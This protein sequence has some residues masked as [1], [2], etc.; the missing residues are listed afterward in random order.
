[1]PGKAIII[2]L[3]G[4]IVIMGMVL[5]GI[6]NT[7]NNISKNMVSDYQR[8]EAYNI[9]Q[10]GAN[11]G[12]RKLKNNPAYRN[13]SY[14]VFDMMYGK[15][16][17]RVIDTTMGAS[18]VVAVKSTGFINYGK[19]DSIVYTT[20]AIAPKIVNPA[21][22][23]GAFNSPS[24]VT[25]KFNGGGEID[26]RNY[27]TN[28]QLISPG[29]TGTYG[30]WTTGTINIPGSSAVIG[31]TAN[32]IDY[33]PSPNPDTSIVRQNQVYDPGYPTNADQVMGG[34][35]AG[36]PDG[37]LM[38]AAKSGALGSQYIKSQS[39]SLP[40]YNSPF[41]GITYIDWSGGSVNNVSG[42]GILIINNLIPT[43]LSIEIKS[44]T[45]TGIVILSSNI[46]LSVK[47]GGVVGTVV[48]TGP[49]APTSQLSVNGQG[50]IH[51]SSQAIKNGINGIPFSGKVV[52][53]ER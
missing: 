46:N 48:V 30:V 38:S 40:T 6:L 31:G 29:G 41:S 33:A 32:G 36:F 39:G 4:M 28:N 2:L 51:Y 22:I 44:S 11:I 10:S 26:G 43:N 9:A 15:V 8:K 37:T 16:N 21:I 3:L 50:Y 34:A 35:N 5:G 18:N 27:N 42:S 20:I 52:W 45:F 13:T 23:K 12:L 14:S 19:A 1:M 24:G 17:I 25:Y 7:S 53:F 49:N 47:Q